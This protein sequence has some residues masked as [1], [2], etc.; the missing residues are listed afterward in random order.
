MSNWNATAFHHG[1]I[2]QAGYVVDDEN[3]VIAANLNSSMFTALLMGIYTAVFGGTM[4][5][6]LTRQPSKHTLVPITVSLLYL[7]NLAVFS[8][9]WYITKLQFIDNDQSR[10]TIFLATIESNQRLT[11]GVDIGNTISLVLSDA[12][13][14]WR[15]F[16]VWSRSIRV[17]SIPVILVITEAVSMFTGT[18]AI[19]ILPPSA[20]SLRVQMGNIASAGVLMSACTTIITTALITSRIHSFLK[21]QDISSR[22]FWHIIDIVVQSGAVYSLSVVFYGAAN[23]VQSK[24]LNVRTFIFV[25][26]INFAVPLAG[27]ST[28]LMVARVATLSDDT[29]ISTPLH[30]TGIQFKAHSTAYITSK[31]MSVPLY[32]CSDSDAAG[33]TEAEMKKTQVLTWNKK[34][35]EYV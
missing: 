12:L 5:A 16:N 23:I 18:I 32:T 10:T 17:V 27:M 8:I 13:L 20:V 2:L 29:N 7:S 33:D 3:S 30:L 21:H 34:I 19:A 9:Q 1:T 6:Y 14:I 4:Y 11:A 25:L 26:W 28:T 15:C 35:S 22:K 24:I 31:D